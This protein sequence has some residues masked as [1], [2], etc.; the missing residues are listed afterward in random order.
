MSGFFWNLNA[1]SA[2][3]L[4]TPL[5]DHSSGNPRNFCAVVTLWQNTKA[6]KVAISCPCGSLAVATDVRLRVKIWGGNRHESA[7]RRPYQ[8]RSKTIHDENPYGFRPFR[9]V[10]TF[11]MADTGQGASNGLH[12]AVE[13]DETQLRSQ[14]CLAM[15]DA[16]PNYRS[17]CRKF[18]EV[19]RGCMNLCSN[20]KDHTPS[21]PDERHSWYWGKSIWARHL[22]PTVTWPILFDGQG[23][24][25]IDRFRN[26]ILVRI[27]PNE[28]ANS[29]VKATP[30]YN[31]PAI[32]IDRW[33]NCDWCWGPLAF[34]LTYPI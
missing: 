33:G 6:E 8:S 17:D 9:W 19:S 22:E 27:I 28:H 3:C 1:W 20:L 5:Y 31:H 15:Q 14:I 26:T 18:T 13:V 29:Q 34:T 30:I 21:C 12:R 32:E 25:K 24:G 11:F 4:N 16:I 10:S 23:Q 7:T 2:C